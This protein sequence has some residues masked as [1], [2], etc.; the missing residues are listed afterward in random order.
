VEEPEGGELAEGRPNH[1]LG[2]FSPLLPQKLS[3]GIPSLSRSSLVLPAFA[4]IPV[5]FSTEDQL[6]S[7]CINYLTASFSSRACQFFSHYLD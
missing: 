7:D 6:S 1:Y 4:S 2:I 3:Q 5:R